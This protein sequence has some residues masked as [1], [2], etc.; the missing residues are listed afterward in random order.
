LSSADAAENKKTCSPECR[1]ALISRIK[2][3]LGEA[4]CEGCGVTYKV[5]RWHI[6]AGRRF[7]GDTCRLAWFSSITQ[8]GAA[9]ANWKG[10]PPRYYGR[11]GWRRASRDARRRAGYACEECGATQVALGYT[12]N[13]HHIKPLKTFS[14]EEHE[15]AHNLSN[16][17][18]L[19]RACHVKIESRDNPGYNSRKGRKNRSKRP[20]LQ[21]DL[22][23]S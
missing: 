1:S 20:L 6:R 23:N 8:T 19:C 21:E 9:N 15:I 10:G 22:C 12:L 16:L 5:S 7:C 17:K 11:V 4:V 13:V 14:V 18:C 2:G 3:G